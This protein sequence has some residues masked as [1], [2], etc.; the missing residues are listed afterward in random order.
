[1]LR[2]LHKLYQSTTCFLLFPFAV[3]FSN[4]SPLTLAY[5][6]WSTLLLGVCSLLILA[7]YLHTYVHSFTLFSI[8]FKLK[9]PFDKYSCFLFDFLTRQMSKS[10]PLCCVYVCTIGAYVSFLLASSTLSH[11][12]FSY[13]PLTALI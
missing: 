3:D 8:K 13:H 11:S 5:A 2:F 9:L 7:R 1:M 12:K 6:K 10:W 4:L